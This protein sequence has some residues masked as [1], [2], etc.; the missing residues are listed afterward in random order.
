MSFGR[1]EQIMEQD[2]LH[3]ALH[4]ENISSHR[5]KVEK[6]IL[7]IGW[8][9]VDKKTIKM[10]AISPIPKYPMRHPSFR[11]ERY[12]SMI[13]PKCSHIHFLLHDEEDWSRAALARPMK[14]PPPLK[15]HSHFPK[16][17]KWKCFTCLFLPFFRAKSH[18]TCHKRTAP[19]AHSWWTLYFE[20]N[21]LFSIHAFP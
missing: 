3:K 16:K 9:L 7:A 4:V 15:R 18:T 1:L 20:A 21:K 6:F 13:L 2:M 8:S 12:L 17:V 5:S 10:E 14:R 19:P 11:T